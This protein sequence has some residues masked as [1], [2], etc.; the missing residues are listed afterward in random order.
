MVVC[1][2]LQQCL[3]LEG[4]ILQQCCFGVVEGVWFG[5]DDIQGI[6]VMIV[7]CFDGVFGVEMN[8]WFI[9]DVCCVCE[10]FVMQCVFDYE[11]FGL[12]DGQVVECICLGDGFG[13]Y[14]VD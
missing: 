4:E 7:G 6:D 10:F 13:F 5:V 14:F 12:M 9:D 2:F 8:L 11:N 3:C 1:L